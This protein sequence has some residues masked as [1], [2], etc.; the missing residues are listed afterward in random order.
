MPCEV[1]WRAGIGCPEVRDGWPTI[2]SVDQQ[3]PVLANE[4][5]GVNASGGDSTATNS[6]KLQQFETCGMVVYTNVGALAPW[7]HRLR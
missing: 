5:F 7:R 1:G 4:F 2:S 6:M 3:H